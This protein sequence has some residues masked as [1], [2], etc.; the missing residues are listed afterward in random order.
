MF[1]A[2]GLRVGRYTSPHLVEFRERILVNGQP[3]SEAEVLKFLVRTMPFA[4]KI[5]ATFFELTTALAF[6]HFDESRVDVAVVETGLGGRL[7][8]TNVLAPVTATVTSIGLDHTELLGDSLELIAAEKAGIFKPDIP[9]I[10]GD[11][12]P[13]IISVLRKHA[14]AAGA[15]PIRV[16]DHQ[17][18]VSEVKVASSGT[19]FVFDTKLGLRAMRTNLI[20]YHQAQN[21]AVAVTTVR[22]ATLGLEP[23]W[24]EIARGLRAV[25]LPGRFQRQGKYIFDG[26]HNPEAARVL[27][28]TVI[29]VAPDRPVTAVIAV[30]SDK[31]WRGVLREVGQVV[32]RLIITNAP[33]APADRK[34]DGNA[35]LSYCG[36]L[37]FKCAA[38]PD[39]ATALR[40]ASDGAAT[41]IVTGSFHTVGDAM[42]RLQ[43][44]PFAA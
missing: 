6:S 19:S 17:L 42:S 2:K 30:L 37:G 32:D 26:A 11:R 16:V 8:S 35:A 13:A 21:A 34:W 9:A 23:E 25:R 22:A 38:E 10:I 7:D 41:V 1:R 15:H 40:L 5:G 4:E 12:N 24:D 36:E 18:H 28:Q 44:S 31:D 3:I 43:V 20:G 39:L 27:A 33:S 14:A 29:A